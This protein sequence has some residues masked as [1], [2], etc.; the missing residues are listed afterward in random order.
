[1]SLF[2]ELK[3]RNVFRVAAAYL[4]VAW[5][6]T[7]ILATLLPMFGV[8]DWVGKAVVIVVALTFIPVLIFAWAFEMTP[9]GIKREKDVDRDSSITSDTGKKL[10][11]VTI[12]AVVVGIGFLAFSR[13]ETPAP[14]APIEI[15]ETTGAPSVAVLPFVNMS[16]N[17]ENEYFSDGLTETLLHML[18][19]VP[20]IK[21]AAR[22]SSFAFKGEDQDI[23]KIAL[24]LGVAHVLE[25]SVQ[26]SGD[27]VRVTA[28]LI[29][30][31]DGFHVWSSIYDRQLNDIFAIQ[32]EIAADV[33]E[34]LTASLLGDEKVE[35]AGIGTDNIIAYDLY[36]QALSLRA[37]GSY[38]ALQDAEALLKESLLMDADFLDAKSVLGIVYMMQASTGLTEWESALENAAS[39]NE[40]ILHVRPDDIS[41]QSSLVA[42]RAYQAEES[43]AYMAIPDA[44]PVLSNLVS[45]APKDADLRSLYARFLN[46]TGRAEDALVEI[47]AALLIDPVSARLYQQLGTAY[48]NVENIDAARKALNRS[49]EINPNQPNVHGRLA[50]SYSMEGDGLGTVKSNLD[51]I[52]L[53]PRDQELASG[54]GIFLYRLGL[55]EEADEFRDRAVLLAPNSPSARHV[56]LEAAKARQDS[57]A[58]DSIARSMIADDIDERHGS[59]IVAAYT[60]MTNAI[61]REDAAAGLEFIEQFVPGFNDPTSNRLSFKVRNAQSAAFGAWDA[62]FGRE[63][64]SQM[65]DDFWRIMQ[66]GGHVDEDW[67]DAV[68]EIKA[69]KGET[70]S[71]I[72]FGL[73]NVFNRQATETIFYWEIYDA[74]HL[75]E[76][77]ADPRIQ[78]RLQQWEEDAVRTR[79][80]I[81]SFFD[82]RS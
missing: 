38:E 56:Q 32:D 24:A 49:L 4:I 25:G 20:D 57:E 69:L 59:Y 51:A 40:Q 39:M 9:E 80:E 48:L 58:S 26:R 79:A 6:L 29:R 37:T 8:P 12:A 1:M 19:Q 65:A 35:I 78:A 17:A 75:S 70:E 76:V 30:A 41:A 50:R 5:L 53:D 63:T 72:E 47:E 22:T 62:V 54:L 3:R 68:M 15:T 36:L 14:E 16:G 10:D 46:D 55:F 82:E 31:D 60:V 27:K 33:G 11:Y 42:I 44:V 34:S 7:E 77:V 67:P 45:A 74:P 21:V 13:T 64:A 18:A 81:K 2:S 52:A 73:A 71:A 66:A 23:R 28:Q 61:A 43:G